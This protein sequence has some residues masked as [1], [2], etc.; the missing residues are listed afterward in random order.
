VSEALRGQNFFS[1]EK[2]FFFA[3]ALL[4]SVIVASVYL[5]ARQPRHGHPIATFARRLER[6]APLRHDEIVSMK[7]APAQSEFQRACGSDVAGRCDSCHC[8]IFSATL[9]DEQR[10]ATVSTCVADNIRARRDSR[11]AFV[12]CCSPITCDP[13]FAR[14]VAAGACCMAMIAGHGSRRS[15]KLSRGFR[16]SMM[17]SHHAHEN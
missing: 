10:D 8:D 16:R 4:F 3:V 13:S 12:T 7:F 17:T 6:I 9:A 1:G 11:Q 15:R 2:I 5:P 14:L